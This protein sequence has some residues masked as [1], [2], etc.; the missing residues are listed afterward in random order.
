L[1]L[2]AKVEASDFGTALGI[3]TLNIPAGADIAAM[4]NADASAWSWSSNNPAMTAF[5]KPGVEWRYGGSGTY[6]IVE[7]S[8]GPQLSFYSVTGAVKTTIGV[9]QTTASYFG[10][11][12]EMTKIGTDS[13]FAP[14]RSIDLTWANKITD[15]LLLKGDELYVGCET[16]ISNSQINFSY[17][18]QRIIR[19]KSTGNGAMAGFLYKPSERINIGGFYGRYWDRSR[20]TNYLSENSS[21]DSSATDQIKIGASFQV[22]PLTFLACDYQ[23]LNL[24]KMRKG[25]V[26]AGIEQGIVKDIF[27]LYSGWAANGPTC[28]AGLYFK[29]GGFNIAYMQNPFS[30]AN[31]YLGRA[32]VLMAMVYGSF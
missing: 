14:S 7:F 19:S 21:H 5:S 32:R 10:S 29:H 31:D 27:Y 26:F 15:D 28:G 6:G 20:E 22:L 3:A 25:Q 24:P 8:K 18:H 1:C 9:F 4:G 13:K 23:F 2:S 30:E 11:D 16:S 12:T 17:N